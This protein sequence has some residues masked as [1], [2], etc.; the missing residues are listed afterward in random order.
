[1]FNPFIKLTR[2]FVILYPLA[3]YFLPGVFV[4]WIDALCVHFVEQVN[5]V[6]HEDFYD[7]FGAMLGCLFVPTEG[8]VAGSVL[9]NIIDNHH[10]IRV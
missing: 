2:H 3:G 1:M 7:I 4:E 8:I 6:A 5:F 10:D 9:S